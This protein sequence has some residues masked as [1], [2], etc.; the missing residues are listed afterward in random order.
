MSYTPTAD[1][2]SK[3]ASPIKSLSKSLFNGR[4][5]DAELDDAYIKLKKMYSC[6]PA[7]NDL[8]KLRRSYSAPAEITL[9][10]A[11]RCVKELTSVT[12]NAVKLFDGSQVSNSYTP[13]KLREIAVVKHPALEYMAYVASVILTIDN[14]LVMDEATAPKMWC[15]QRDDLSAPISQNPDYQFKL[16][17]GRH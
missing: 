7:V 14:H 3:C 11:V 5:K 17:A 9:G 10:D 13:Q 1:H 4:R 2:L 12:A 8:K 15:D 16:D 6:L